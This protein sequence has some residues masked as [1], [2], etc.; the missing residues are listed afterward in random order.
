MV[1]LVNLTN[2][3]TAAQ[4]EHFEE[5]TD[6]LDVGCP[7]RLLLEISGLPLLVAEQEHLP[8]GTALIFQHNFNR[9]SSV[10]T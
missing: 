7:Y 8:N 1:E 2:S 5:R 4:T 9:F 3:E 10:Y 6:L